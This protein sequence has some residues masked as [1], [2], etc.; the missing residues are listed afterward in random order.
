MWLPGV[1][2]TP[3]IGRRRIQS[4]VPRRGVAVRGLWGAGLYCAMNG[5]VDGGLFRT[6][7]APF[8]FWILYHKLRTA[9][10]ALACGYRVSRL[11]R[12]LGGAG[13]RVACRGGRVGRVG[14]VGGMGWCGVAVK[15][16]Q[17][18]AS[19]SSD[20]RSLWNAASL[21]LQRPRSGRRVSHLRR[22]ISVL[23]SIPQA[24]H[25]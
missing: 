13:W 5:F 12:L 1:A 9:N 19:A 8:P 4:C 23:A 20:A 17:P 6:Y 22:S 16:V 18:H 21:T 10:A 2:A 24:A 14:R 25:G 11:R 7:G 3:L 15:V